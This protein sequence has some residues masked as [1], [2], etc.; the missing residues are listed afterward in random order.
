MLIATQA[1]DPKKIDY[2]LRTIGPNS[3]FALA[4]HH[5]VSK[6][7]ASFVRMG[8]GE[9]M[10][11]KAGESDLSKIVT[12]FGEAW[13]T[14]QACVG[15]T[16]LELKNRILRAGNFSTYFGPSISGLYYNSFLLYE[17]FNP[18]P[19]YIDNFFNSVWSHGHRTAL[20]KQAEGVVVI[21]ADDTFPARLQKNYEMSVPPRFIKHAR[22]Q[23]TDSVIDA[24][25]R[26]QEQ[27]VLFSAGPA[28]KYLASE[29]SSRACK[30]VI[31]V[32]NCMRLWCT[33]NP[34]LYG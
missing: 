32:G 26:G 20:I 33:N 31:D 28:G 18:R 21:H 4:M 7:G 12:M 10:L 9:N 34:P 11:L 23:D 6:T 15:I 14:R 27:L 13:L 30:V 8:D 16:H 29:I 2:C 5:L 24:A 19:F 22:W 1:L 17:W 3:V 25:T